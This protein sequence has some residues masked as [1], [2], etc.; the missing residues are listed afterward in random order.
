MQ[1]NTISVL[2]PTRTR[3]WQGSVVWPPPDS[4][5]PRVASA[6]TQDRETAAAAETMWGAVKST[7]YNDPD[8]ATSASALATPVDQLYGDDIQITAVDR[9]A[10][11]ISF[12]VVFYLIRGFLFSFC[13]SQ[14]LRHGVAHC[15]LFVTQNVQVHDAGHAESR[16]E[17]PTG[18][19]L[20]DPGASTHRSCSQGSSGQAAPTRGSPQQGQP[21]RV[22]RSVQAS[23]NSV[24]ASLF[25]FL[26]KGVDMPC[27]P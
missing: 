17:F 15:K 7:I 26:E 1:K 5:L 19:G 22:L 13:L 12:E 10:A 21:A 11:M 16:E 3:L 27:M 8:S 14:L 4:S 18:E 24:S 2:D 20:A 9:C 25:N 23:S 6:S